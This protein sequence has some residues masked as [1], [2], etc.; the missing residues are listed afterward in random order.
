MGDETAGHWEGTTEDSSAWETSA[1][2]VHGQW[3]EVENP[4]V[5]ATYLELAEYCKFRRLMTAYI[6]FVRHV[7]KR[8]LPEAVD[9]ADDDDVVFIQGI[10]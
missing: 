3:I 8:T 10:Q 2:E 6:D 4:L 1:V 7:D 5:D 9:G